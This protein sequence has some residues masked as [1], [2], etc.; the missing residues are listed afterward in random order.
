M[1]RWAQT[2]SQGT[3]VALPEKG[4]YEIRSVMGQ[5][6]LSYVSPASIIASRTV[7]FPETL[8]AVIDGVVTS[9][10]F[11]PKG[12][13]LGDGTYSNLWNELAIRAV[14]AGAGLPSLPP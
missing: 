9:V 8:F 12:V 1:T 13:L 5:P 2:G 7:P 14:L 11:F 6:L 3:W 10:I 4:S